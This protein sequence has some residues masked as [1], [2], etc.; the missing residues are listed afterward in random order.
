MK[1]DRR[2]SQAEIHLPTLPS[3]LPGP[4]AF[5]GS[6]ETDEAPRFVAWHRP[7]DR[8]ARKGF[9]IA[10]NRNTSEAPCSHCETSGCRQPAHRIQLVLDHL[11][12]LLRAEA[13]ARGPRT[14]A[15]T[16]ESAYLNY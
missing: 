8:F 1:N 4:A 15:T 10:A 3:S 16:D 5:P 2:R 14:I 6:S 12:T 11:P 7:L 9:R 13:T